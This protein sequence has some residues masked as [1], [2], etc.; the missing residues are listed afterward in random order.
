MARDFEGKVAEWRRDVDHVLFMG[1]I[2]LD[3]EETDLGLDVL[4]CKI[5]QILHW[6]SHALSL[7]VLAVNCAYHYYDERGFWVHFCGKLSLEDT[8]AQ[9]TRLGVVIER[10]LEQRFTSFNKRSG[11][12]RFVGGI[13]EQCGVAR[14]FLHQFADLL[15]QLDRSV[16]WTGVQRLDHIGYTG[17]IPESYSKFFTMFLK[18]NSGWCFVNDIARSLSQLQRGLLTPAQLCR[19]RGY[20]PGFWQELLPL[21]RLTA[22]L[23]HKRVHIPPSKPVWDNPVLSW[24]NVG[25]GLPFFAD[26]QRVFMGKAPRVRIRHPYALVAA[27]YLLILDA[28]EGPRR[29]DPG[30]A[31]NTENAKAIL[32][33]GRCG[34]TPPCKGR[35]WLEAAGRTTGQDNLSSLD[36]A[37]ISECSIS[38]PDRLLTFDESARISLSGPA[39]YRLK[40]P[41]DMAR[42]ADA[43]GRVWEIGPGIRQA[44]GIM[45]TGR[46]D[47]AL[48]L[49]IYRDIVRCQDGSDLLVP[50]DIIAERAVIVSGKPGDRLKLYLDTLHDRECIFENGPV[51]ISGDVL[52][53]P[54][55]FGAILLERRVPSGIL[56]QGSGSRA[57]GLKYLDIA[58]LLEL[59]TKEESFEDP[60]LDMGFAGLEGGDVLQGLLLTLSG[61]NR[62][63]FDANSIGR[64]HGKLS[65]GAWVAATC[66]AVLDRLD[67]KGV[68]EADRPPVPRYV[69]QTLNWYRKASAVHSDVDLQAA[70]SLLQAYPGTT[71]LPTSRWRK[72][73][74]HARARLQEIIRSG[75]DLSPAILEWKAQIEGRVRTKFCGFIADSASGQALTIAW[76][77]YHHRNATR[78]VVYSQARDLAGIGG[79]VGDLARLLMSLLLRKTGRED[80]LHTVGAVDV[81]PLLM[82]YM[83]SLQ[84]KRQAEHTFDFFIIPIL[85]EDQHLF[86]WT[87]DSPDGETHV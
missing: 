81:H 4:G 24:E 49:T 35:L 55:R 38:L 86:S 57:G 65:E 77:N 60:W 17:H 85:E 64:L 67:I 74:E 1:Q 25:K 46:F 15:L 82:P 31:E 76:R 45:D 18:D 34:V 50:E 68:G 69:Q 8:L 58:A 33:L 40:F 7:T 44:G 41:A 51:G 16:G 56:S 61:K 19:L 10:F 63:P 39:G 52:L 11:P 29:I 28:G 70:H 32:D 13:L 66:A 79:V 26:G 53:G 27:D 3:Q 59:S 48:D 72:I 36:F 12:Y 47:V 5:R 83:R 23:P 43:K 20:R 87:K 73:I 62:E 14:R 6:E 30:Y 22:P 71:S 75:S 9:Q 37:V 2:A 78:E 84:G 42:Q 54:E 80:L 21:L